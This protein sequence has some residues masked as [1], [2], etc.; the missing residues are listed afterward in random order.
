[1]RIRKIKKKF[2]GPF[3]MTAIKI[4]IVLGFLVGVIPQSVVAPDSPGGGMGILENEPPVAVALP[5]YQEVFM[6][7]YA[8]FDGS[9]SYDP[10][11]TIESYEW[12]FGDGFFERGM[13]VNHTYEAPAEYPVSLIVTD[14]CGLIDIDIIIIIIIDPESPPP[15]ENQ[16]PVAICEPQ[17]QLIALGETAFFDGSFSH[18][19]DGTIVSYE[20]D[21]GDTHSASGVFVN[22]TYE[23]IGTY[24]V[25][26]TVTDDE[27]AEGYG[28]GYVDVVDDNNPPPC[29]NE[30]PVACAEPKFQMTN[31]NESARFDGSGSF[32]PDGVIVSYMWDFGDGST[33]SGMIVNHSYDKQGEYIVTLTVTDNEGATGSDFI[34]VFV[35]D[36]PPPP[37]EVELPPVAVPEPRYQE[38][39]VGENA[40]FNGSWSYDPDGVIVSYEWEFGDNT[41]A[42]G[43]EVVHAYAEA[44]K[45]IVKLTVWDDDGLYNYD[46][47]VVQVWDEVPP[48]CENDPPVAIAEP[49]FQEILVNE[50]AVFEGGRSYD[51]D[52]YIVSYEW[53]FGDGWTGSGASIEHMY[54]IPGMYMVILTV[55]DDD[56]ATG[57]DMC[58]VVV[59]DDNVPP[60]SENCPPV[61][62]AEPK[63]QEITLTD[64]AQFDGSLSFD[65]DGTIM[66]YEW[67]FGDGT[68]GMGVITEH[69]YDEDGFYL[70]TL[71][72]TDDDNA[73]SSDIAHVLVCGSKPPWPGMNIPPEAIAISMSQE[74]FIGQYVRIDGTE[75]F[76]PDG[77]IVT[78]VWTFED[79]TCYFGRSISHK[80]DRLGTYTVTLTVTDD[81]GA[82]ASTSVTY[83]VV[84]WNSNPPLEKEVPEVEKD[85][86]LDK[87]IPLDN[88][89]PVLILTAGLINIAT[90]GP[91]NRGHTHCSKC[92]RG[93]DS[94]IL[95]K[96]Q[97]TRATG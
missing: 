35:V 76:D 9:E 91:Q 4:L 95:P 19:P 93:Q 31:V 54:T 13:S 16:P 48:P 11:G 36:C 68:K 12:D 39:K 70:V 85:P 88:E 59:F 67:D 26:L 46:Y 32:D 72:V 8:K 37:P 17:Y 75:S 40:T 53:D 79:G 97:G 50:T 52:G 81:L 51:T 25:M 60:P 22:H 23:V 78:H 64:T 42:S 73:T 84:E 44:G 28:L 24:F 1:M 65:L 82:K 77:Y 94:E 6:G 41:S 47:C 10:D 90:R 3:L 5:E 80:T 27:G 89:E 14:N 86:K 57:S 38:V 63:Y 7:D 43:V 20:W 92:S 87:D 29:E 15:C 45:Y 71:T 66:S 34:I 18:D 61:A 74:V 56:N 58:M 2:V 21:F 69:Q 83:D 33:G 55:M 62:V 96:N 49:K 30:P